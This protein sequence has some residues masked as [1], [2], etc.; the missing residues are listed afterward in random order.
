MLNRVDEDAF[1]KL[2]HFPIDVHV[3]VSK[4]LENKNLSSLSELK[5]IAWVCLYNNKEDARNHKVV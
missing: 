1:E 4:N 5:N 2:N 3:L